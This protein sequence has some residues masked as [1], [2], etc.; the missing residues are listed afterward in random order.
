MDPFV[1]NDAEIFLSF[2]K[3][4]L[5]QQLVFAFPILELDVIAQHDVQL[6]REFLSYNHFQIRAIYFAA[7]HHDSSS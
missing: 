6:D 5:Y 1:V 2:D 3:Q 7:T 4:R